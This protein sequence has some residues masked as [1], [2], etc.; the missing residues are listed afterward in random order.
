MN[1]GIVLAAATNVTAADAAIAAMKTH[2]AMD[3]ISKVDA[4]VGNKADAVEEKGV[5]AKDNKVDVVRADAA[6]VR[7]NKANL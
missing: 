1:S 3:R 4:A 6:V 5:V 7:A 2:V